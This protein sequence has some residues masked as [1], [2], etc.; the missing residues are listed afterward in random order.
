M[1]RR[2]K[3]SGGCWCWCLLLV[4]LGGIA[5][6]VYIVMRNSKS[7]SIFAPTP[8]ISKEYSD[9]LK[10]ALKFFDIQKCT[11]YTFFFQSIYVF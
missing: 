5:F 1:D 9:A 10:I 4:V 6:A 7:G 3:K 8:V 11:L 2:K